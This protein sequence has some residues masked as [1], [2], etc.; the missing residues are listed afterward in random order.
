MYTGAV[1]RS[2]SPSDFSENGRRSLAETLETDGYSEVC[3]G[4][5]SWKIRN[6]KRKKKVWRGKRL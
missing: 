3:E 4:R 5:R 1:P 2:S 6:L